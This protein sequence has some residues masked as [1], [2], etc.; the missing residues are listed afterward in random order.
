MEKDDIF[1][2]FLFTMFI[3][4]FGS[5]C[6]LVNLVLMLLISDWNISSLGAFCIGA[7]WMTLQCI[8]Y[9]IIYIKNR[10]R[11]V[12]VRDSLNKQVQKTLGEQHSGTS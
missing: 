12:A 9:I 5:G 7:G 6:M 11:E 1:C 2:I 10:K 4:L 8:P 3:L